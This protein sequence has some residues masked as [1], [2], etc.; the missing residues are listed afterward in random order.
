MPSGRERACDL[1]TFIQSVLGRSLSEVIRIANDAMGQASRD[2]DRKPAARDERARFVR[3]LSGLKFLL[4]TGIRPPSVES[5]RFQK[6]RP[7][8][9]LLVR[10]G[11]MNS[12]AL[13]AFTEVTESES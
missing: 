3:A 1:D 5:D 12:S 13:D 11:E 2:G 10:K 6:F 4:G 8:V 7:L 9:E